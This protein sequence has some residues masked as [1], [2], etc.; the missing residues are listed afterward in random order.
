MKLVNI[1]EAIFL[2]I[3]Q[4]ITEVLPISSS[5]HLV[6]MPWIFKF[7]DP[8]LAFDV[9]LHLGT[10]TAIIIYFWQDILSI[11]RSFI[12][13]VR[14]RQIK[15]FD[16][17][18][19]YLIMLATIPGVVFGYFLDSLAEKAF[20]SPLIVAATTFFFA[21]VLL[22]VERM[23][24]QKKMEGMTTKNAFFTGLG[25][26]IAIVPGVSRSGI[27]ISAGMFQGFTR[28]SAAKFSFLISIP[29]IAGAGLIQVRK[30]PVQEF[31][32]SV[33]WAGLIAAILA[34][35][36][37]VKFLMSFVKN[38]KLNVFA[39]YR[40]GLAALIIILYLWR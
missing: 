19:P 21:L 31:S 1:F 4:G 25:Q 9:A 5:G 16:D 32:T 13:T 11:I 35:F 26:A 10:L 27:T 23:D 18:L 12:K 33:F 3:V 28:E 14:K 6:I 39:Y 7:P 22:W 8:G 37:S 15:S 17:R 40:F 20:R 24:H 29:I 2:G 34:S 30:I 36:V 38:H